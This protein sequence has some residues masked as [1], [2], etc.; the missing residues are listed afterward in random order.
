M[1]KSLLIFAG[2][3]LVGAGCTLGPQQTSRPTVTPPSIEGPESIVSWDGDDAFDGTARV[4]GTFVNDPERPGWK[5]YTDT[6]HGFSFSVPTDESGL[7]TYFEATFYPLGSAEIDQEGCVDPQNRL[8]STREEFNGIWYC[9]SVES[10]AAMGHTY[11][12]T[13]YANIVVSG[14]FAIGYAVEEVSC[15]NFDPV[16]RPACEESNADA[17]ER[18]RAL[19]EKIL[20]TIVVS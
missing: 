18:N 19:F 17:V 11:T 10:S 13:M 1:K 15:Y 5:L 6:W 20:D 3:C 12:T 2:F 9:V 7:P 14:E 4:T 16:D 8:S